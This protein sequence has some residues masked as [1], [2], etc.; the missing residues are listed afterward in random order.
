MMI[1]HTI[2]LERCLL[3][4]LTTNLDRRLLDVEHLALGHPRLQGY[5]IDIQI[6]FVLVDALCPESDATMAVDAVN[7]HFPQKGATI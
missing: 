3:F 1:S 5:F 7:E 2:T 4:T 6:L